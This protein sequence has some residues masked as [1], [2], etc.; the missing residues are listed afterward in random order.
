MIY[1]IGLD[2]QEIA[3]IGELYVRRKDA[4]LRKVFTPDELAYCQRHAD[5]GQH[6]AARWAV[7]EAFFKAMGV[8]IGGGYALTDVET[9]NLPSGKPHVVLHGKPLADCA[10]LGLRVFVSLSHSGEYAAAQ[11]VL[12]VD[13]EDT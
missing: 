12:E 4:F 13:R 3:Q 5:P 7:K 1:G 6:L 8:G 9:V 11:I 2:I 10:R